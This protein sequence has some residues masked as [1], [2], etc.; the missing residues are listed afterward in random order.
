M[1]PREQGL[2]EELDFWR[3]VMRFGG[4]WPREWRHCFNPFKPLDTD[5][6]ELLPAKQRV[7]ILDVGAG[8]VTTLGYR[9]LNRE[10]VIVP[11]DPLANEYNDLLFEMN[12]NPPVRTMRC[13][14]EELA[15][16]FVNT[17]FDLCYARNS[18]D[19][20]ENPVEIIEQ[21]LD[22]VTPGGVVYLLHCDREADRQ[23]GQGLHRWNIYEHMSC[24]FV[25][26]VDKARCTNVNLLVEDRASCE[27]SQTGGWVKAILRKYV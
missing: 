25:E 14:G 18:L 5:I 15:S 23:N 21:M 13:G 12:Y 16:M 2:K 10:V 8:P 19:H 6:Q 17:Q 3:E 20:S 26:S 27:V 1:T 22:V 24:L 11:T 7:H 9:W 4:G